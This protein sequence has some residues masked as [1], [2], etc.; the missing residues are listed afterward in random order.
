MSHRGS[1]RSSLLLAAATSASSEP[2]IPVP[3][4]VSPLT[5]L[6]CTLPTKRKSVL[7]AEQE[8]FWSLLP[9]LEPS[10]KPVVTFSSPISTVHLFSDE[11]SSV[12]DITS[13]SISL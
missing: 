4:R 8:L 1:R 2:F 11:P 13:S 9:V 12:L 5:L 7:T 6:H 10:A 3:V